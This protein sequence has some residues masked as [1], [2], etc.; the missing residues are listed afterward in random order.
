MERRS[1]VPRLVRLRCRKV[2]EGT[3]TADHVFP[4]RREV[5]A[6]HGRASYWNLPDRHFKI[7]LRKLCHDESIRV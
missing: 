5:L 4:A 7:K 2:D 1:D 3:G 6:H